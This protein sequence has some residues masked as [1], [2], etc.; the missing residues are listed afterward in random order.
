MRTENHFHPSAGDAEKGVEQHR[1]Q[2]QHQEQTGGKTKCS[3]SHVKFPDSEV[4]PLFHRVEQQVETECR[5]PVK[6]GEFAA[7]G[8]SCQQTAPEE[9][10]QRAG[11]QMAQKK[12]DC[13][14]HVE[15]RRHHR[16]KLGA[17]T[18][19]VREETDQ[20]ECRNTCRFAP[21]FCRNPHLS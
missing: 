8:D 13:P 14:E 19:C 12:N 4:L 11:F 3:R 5:R 17:F 6:R 7:V 16:Q 20:K 1:F 15:C 18:H 21:K 9:R 2:N 10:H